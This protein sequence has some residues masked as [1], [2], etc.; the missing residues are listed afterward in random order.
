[1]NGV[2]RWSIDELIGK[3]ERIN[4][5][6]DDKQKLKGNL[7]DWL[8]LLGSNP[9]YAEQRKERITS[10]LKEQNKSIYAE[11]EAL[12]NMSVRN[13]LYD[14]LT[15]SSIKNITKTEQQDERH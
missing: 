2:I 3:V 4:S 14:I 6:G 9:G 15:L 11:V 5:E 10:Q 8:T 12:L 1:L 13:P 7:R